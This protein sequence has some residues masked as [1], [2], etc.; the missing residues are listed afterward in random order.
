MTENKYKKLA[1]NTLIF[2]IGNLG[3][4]LIALLMVPLYTYTLTTKDY[5]DV[6]LLQTTMSLLLPLATLSISQAVMRFV[7]RDIKDETE[8]KKTFTTSTL[9]VLLMSILSAGIVY[10]ILKIFHAYEGMEVYFLLFLL[11]Q[12]VSEHF[13]QF[14]R[15]IGKVKEFAFNGILMTII[16]AGLNVLLLVNLKMGTSGYLLSFLG[17]FIA[18]TLYMGAV[19]NL[20][21]HFSLKFLSKE[22][23]KEL[24]KFS[25]PLIPNGIMWWLINGSTRYFIL[26][27]IG[28]GANGIFAV[29][30]K[31]PAIMT[32]FVNIFSQAWQISAYEEYTKEERSAF[33][34]KVFQL[35]AQF[36]FLGGS[37]ILVIVKPLL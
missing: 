6:D 31:I 35:Q 10:L 33:Y 20:K 26:L 24:L 9:F 23:L 21:K 13:T 25:T 5:G 7:L 32:M 11:V 14:A 30:N 28:A 17:A 1:S 2:T 8:V 34:T 18:S 16:A 36:L 22:T 19:I 37:A 15:A 27:F 3:S 29:A 4:K 12:P